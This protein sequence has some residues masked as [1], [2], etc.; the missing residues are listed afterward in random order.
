MPQ[1]HKESKRQKLEQKYQVL[2]EQAFAVPL[3]ADLCPSDR[4]LASRP[5]EAF[6]CGLRGSP[7]SKR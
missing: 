1:V 5:N 7:I 4:A 6:E 3:V 2:Q